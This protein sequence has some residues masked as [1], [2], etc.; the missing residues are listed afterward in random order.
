MGN[1][2]NN[3]FYEIY[4]PKLIAY[5]E[6]ELLTH[7]ELAQRLGIGLQVYYR[8]MKKSGIRMKTK[9]KVRDFFD[10]LASVE[11]NNYARINVIQ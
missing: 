7:M 10:G 2:M 6:K 5:R 9:R 11:V 3:D 8:L 1:C 4:I